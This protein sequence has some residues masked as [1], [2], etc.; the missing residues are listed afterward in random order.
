M[1]TFQRAEKHEEENERQQLVLQGNKRVKKLL[2]VS[3]PI[4][5]TPTPGHPHDIYQHD[6]APPH[7]STAGAGLPTSKTQHNG[8]HTAG[9]Q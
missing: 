9:V 6:T 3:N 7:T 8:K 5:G 2:F 4:Q 1:K